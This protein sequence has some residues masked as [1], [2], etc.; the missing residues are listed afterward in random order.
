MEAAKERITSGE[1]SFF[2]LMKEKVR[3]FLGT[4]SACVGYASSVLRHVN[5]FSLA[6]NSFY[7]AAILLAAVGLIRL[8]RQGS[9]SPV[10]AGAYLGADAGGGG[11]TLPLFHSAGAFAAGAGGPLRPRP[12]KNKNFSKNAGKPL[13]EHGF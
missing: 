9:R 2:H 7:Y 8:W 10:C 11:G 5:F 6:C 3:I 13:T 12:G 4:D 1:I